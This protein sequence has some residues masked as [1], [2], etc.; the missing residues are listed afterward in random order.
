[1]NETSGRSLT[2]HPDRKRAYESGR[3]CGRKRPALVIWDSSDLRETCLRINELHDP[4][5]GVLVAHVPPRGVGN[6]ATA[7]LESLGKDLPPHFGPSQW[8]HELALR[9]LRGEGITDVV[10]YGAHRIHD[11]LWRYVEFGPRF[12]FVTPSK[13]CAE[14]LQERVSPSWPSNLGS[15]FDKLKPPK[16]ETKTS[17]QDDPFPEVPFNGFHSFLAA[18]YELCPEPGTY[19]RIELTFREASAKAWSFFD[20][21][22]SVP[23]LS[24]LRKL[25][26]RYL[27]ESTDD[28]QAVCRLRGMQ[29]AFFW[30]GLALKSDLRDLLGVLRLDRRQIRTSE[31]AN[32]TRKSHDH[33]NPSVAVIA[34]VSDLTNSQ[35]SELR[36]DSLSDDVSELTHD[37][38]TW[39]IPSELRA[40]LRILRAEWGNSATAKKEHLFGGHPQLLKALGIKRALWAF[41]TRFGP[42]VRGAVEDP[43][44]RAGRAPLL[45]RHISISAFAR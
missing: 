2:H 23:D 26:S 6:F 39:K 43:D 11:D 42:D 28:R 27:V 17:D 34:H 3:P 25:V 7:I 37:G 35:I 41:K 8:D 20:D 16:V 44:R 30:N 31:L 15:L 45:N 40:P 5:N 36:R 22:G 24:Q 10:V 19:D 9:W 18:C 4:D 1:M 12:F 13:S 38:S 33:L 14:S 29:A 32:A 21:G